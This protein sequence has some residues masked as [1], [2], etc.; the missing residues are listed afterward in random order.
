MSIPKFITRENYRELRK[1]LLE[2]SE[3]YA[4]DHDSYVIALLV[5]IELAAECNKVAKITYAPPEGVQ[6]E[7]VT[8]ESNQAPR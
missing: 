1:A 4:L 6:H 7:N 2:E 5:G 3:V 8:R